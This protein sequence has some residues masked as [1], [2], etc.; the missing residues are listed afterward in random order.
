MARCHRAKTLAKKPKNRPS[1][2]GMPLGTARLRRLA[3]PAAC[4]G[5]RGSV[6][7]R[8]FDLLGLSCNGFS[9][10]NLPPW[11]S[12]LLNIVY[13]SVSSIKSLKI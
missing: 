3:A 10:L 6:G 4:A 2:T 12:F 11:H 1:G 5:F 9:R 7:Y 8:C 13:L